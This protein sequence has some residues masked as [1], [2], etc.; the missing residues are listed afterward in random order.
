MNSIVFME[1]LE[2]N[3]IPTLTRHSC[4]IIDMLLTTIKGYQALKRLQQL[5]EKL[6]FVPGWTRKKRMHK[7]ELYAVAKIH[8]PRIKYLTDQI[9]E[10]AG[11]V[12]IRTPVRHWIFNV[13]EEIWAP[14][15]DYIAVN[16]DTYKL[17]HVE[18]FVPDALASVSIKIWRDA[19]KS[20]R[21]KKILLG[22]R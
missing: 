7:P 17:A 20:A 15:K 11:H 5:G 2:E 22:N 4:I 19:V 13:I 14:V 9:A 21:K 1:W 12:V 8:K 6:I 16:N 18:K 10:A 3:P